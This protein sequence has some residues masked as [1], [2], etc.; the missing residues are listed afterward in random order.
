M[1]VRNCRSCG[2]LFNYVGGMGILCPACMDKLEEKFQQ[3]KK[4]IR[5]NPRATIQQVSEENEVSISQIERWIRDERLA[6]SEDSPI[7]VACEACGV[8]IKTGKYCQTCKD[9]MAKNLGSIYSS[10]SQAAQRRKD[11]RD[12]AKMRFL[13]N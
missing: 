10:N 7:G 12:R 11:I 3:V 8:T 13:D 2:R 5:E 1:E 4:Y 6:F 9:V